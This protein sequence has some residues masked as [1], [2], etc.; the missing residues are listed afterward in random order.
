[1]KIWSRRG[2]YTIGLAVLSITAIG[3]LSCGAPGRVVAS[4]EPP[5]GDESAAATNAGSASSVPPAPDGAEPNTA[6]SSP[7]SWRFTFP[8]MV[9]N[10]ATADT[11]FHVSLVTSPI[12]VWFFEND[13]AITRVREVGH[14]TTVP[15][16]DASVA[17]I[18]ALLDPAIDGFLSYGVAEFHARDTSVDGAARF[19]AAARVVKQ[20]IE[21]IQDHFRDEVEVHVVHGDPDARFAGVPRIPPDATITYAIADSIA[22]SEGPAFIPIR[23]WTGARPAPVEFIVNA[24]DLGLTGPLMDRLAGDAS[25][26]P[27]IEAVALARQAVSDA[28]AFAAWVQAGAQLDPSVGGIE[29]TP[30]R[31]STDPTVAG[32]E[33]HASTAV[34]RKIV[35]AG[36]ALAQLLRTAGAQDELA[37]DV[38][39]VLTIAHKVIAHNEACLTGFAQGVGCGQYYEVTIPLP[40]P[41]LLQMLNTFVATAKAIGPGG[42][43]ERIE[44]ARRELRDAED[45]LSKARASATAM[46]TM[47]RQSVVDALLRGWPLSART[48]ADDA[49][50]DEIIKHRVPKLW[51]QILDRL[52]RSGVTMSTSLA[53]GD[54]VGP[55]IFYRVTDRGDNTF[56]VVPTTIVHGDHV[57]RWSSTRKSVVVARS[58]E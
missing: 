35:R 58:L 3:V 54:L 13:G 27:W 22:P 47:G 42:A 25:V 39:E 20:R 38:D 23:S 45:A 14:A 52:A 28:K 2:R 50:V 5:P 29:A 34:A 18:R 21:E 43:A 1:M 33:L 4:P 41:G 40:P 37:R 6:A 11:S 31:H 12:R 36:K 51:D 17:L 15:C 55:S 16:H 32:R 7:K 48:T 10:N 8:S 53:G 49:R 46:R 30:K 9:D 26:A 44:N 56:L 19:D 24:T 57:E